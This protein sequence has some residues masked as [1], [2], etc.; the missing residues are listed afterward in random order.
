MGGFDRPVVSLP[1]HERLARHAH[2]GHV[3][4]HATAAE[5]GGAVGMWETFSAPGE[6]PNWHRHS[7]ETEVFRVITG[8]YRFWVGS[9]VLEGG[10]GTV[11]TL[12]PNIPH[13]WRNVSDVP[14]QM[15]GIVTPGGFEAFFFALAET[16]PQ[17][18][19]ELEAIEA[20]FGV[21]SGDIARLGPDPSRSQP[22]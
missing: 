15:F 18:A 13:T 9:E 19:A 14:G 12:P 20:R 1:G 8:T 11:V 2:R 10:P 22:L 17:T 4:I 3:V 16:P 21:L 7:R 5:T 6:G